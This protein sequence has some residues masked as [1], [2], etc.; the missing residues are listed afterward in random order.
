MHNPKVKVSEQEQRDG[1]KT[2]NNSR[3]VE[4]GKAINSI[5]SEDLEEVTNEFIRE[6]LH[7]EVTHPASILSKN[8]LQKACQQLWLKNIEGQEK[9]HK[10]KALLKRAG[11]QMQAYEDAVDQANTKIQLLNEQ[12][13]YLQEQVDVLTEQKNEELGE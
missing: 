7:K 4:V 11:Q 13:Q 3:A 9:V 5:M 1:L 12:N 8:K 10:L 2:L 6:N